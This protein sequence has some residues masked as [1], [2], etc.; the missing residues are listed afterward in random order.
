MTKQDVMSETIA[1]M[2][3]FVSEMQVAFR[4]LSDG[5]KADRELSD[6]LWAE[7][8]LQVYQDDHSSL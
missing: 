5:L 8:D 7:R 2:R 4:E 3:D 1:A 6:R